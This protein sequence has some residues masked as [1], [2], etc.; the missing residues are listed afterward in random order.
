MP[1]AQLY[2]LSVICLLAGLVQVAV[3]GSPVTATLFDVLPTNLAIPAGFGTAVVTASAI[4]VGKDGGT[5]YVMEVI[6]SSVSVE[7]VYGTPQITT[8]I[9]DVSTLTQTFVEQAAW[10]YRSYQD[11]SK[12]FNG[13]ERNCT[14]GTN[15]TTSECV[16][17]GRTVVNGTTTVTTTTTFPAKVAPL[18]TV[19][20]DGA[21]PSQ[22]SSGAL[23]N[24]R[25]ASVSTLSTIGLILTLVLTC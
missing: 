15:G 18:Y 6:D 3:E 19:T 12:E 22:T 7:V 14:I 10:I 4:G 20:R 13:F 21:I 8:T 1:P 23:H 5:T 24:L 17:I 25:F 11:S 9:T 16:V 2:L